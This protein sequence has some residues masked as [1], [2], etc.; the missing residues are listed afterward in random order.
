LIF[1]E[2]E[3]KVGLV[4]DV[5]DFLGLQVPGLVGIEFLWY[6][7]LCLLQFVE[8]GG[9]DGQEIAASEFEDFASVTEGSAYKV[10]TKS[11]AAIPMT[12]VL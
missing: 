1:V 3:P 9:G 5:A 12:M 6:C 2:V 10:R 7:A 11:I 8:E 4:V